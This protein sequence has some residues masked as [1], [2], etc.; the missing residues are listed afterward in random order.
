MQWTKTYLYLPQYEYA[1]SNQHGDRFKRVRSKQF[2]VARMSCK[3][4][5]TD[6]VQKLILL[7]DTLDVPIRYDFNVHEAYIEVVSCE[8]LRRK[9]L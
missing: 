3:I 7:S 8:A 4:S 2:S 5:D 1:S 6:G 9:I